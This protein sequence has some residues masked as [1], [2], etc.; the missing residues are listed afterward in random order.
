MLALDE[1]VTP[2]AGPLAGNL[3]F[4]PNKTVSLDTM[5]K[6]FDPDAQAVLAPPVPP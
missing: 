5:C 3:V 2:A 4:D 1:N 6:F